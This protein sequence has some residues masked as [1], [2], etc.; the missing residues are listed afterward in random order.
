MKPKLTNAQERMLD[1]LSRESIDMLI[2]S[3][4]AEVLIRE[5]LANDYGEPESEFWTVEITE[6]GRKVC[7]GLK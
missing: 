7:E 3:R 6:S 4:T 5:G 1:R 2:I